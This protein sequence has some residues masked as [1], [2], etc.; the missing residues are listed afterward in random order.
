MIDWGEVAELADECE[1]LAQA[2]PEGVPDR[3]Y[4]F[5]RGYFSALL[6]VLDAMGEANQGKEIEAMLEF[7]RDVIR[8]AKGPQAAEPSGETEEAGEEA[9]ASEEETAPAGK[10]S[11]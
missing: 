9:T 3:A 8:G 5:R 11:E 10:E 7:I 2:R 4:Q 6:G 1:R